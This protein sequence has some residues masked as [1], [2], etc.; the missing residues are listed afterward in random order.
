ME[1]GQSQLVLSDKNFSRERNGITQ[2]TKLCGTANRIH[3]NTDS[4]DIPAG[5]VIDRT[6]DHSRPAMT[7]QRQLGIKICLRTGVTIQ[8]IG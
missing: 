3:T 1:A 7:I 2:D 8:V 4:W 6:I 5:L